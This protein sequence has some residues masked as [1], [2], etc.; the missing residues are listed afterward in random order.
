MVLYSNNFDTS[1]IVA[2]GVS[3]TLTPGLIQ[4]SIPLSPWWTGDYYA[5]QTYAPSI[6]SL[7]GAVPA[8]PIDINLTLGFLGSWDS[9]DGH[10]LPDYLDISING[11]PVLM[12]L[13]SNNASGTIQTYGGG[14]VVGKPVIA[15]SNY[16][17]FSDTI[18]DMTTASSLSFTQLGGSL[19]FEILGY[20]GGYS[21]TVTWGSNPNIYDE[22]WGIDNLVI[23]ANNNQSVPAPLPLLGAVSAYRFSRRLKARIRQGNQRRMAQIDTQA[24]L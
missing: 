22:G 11:S 16:L 20:G 15:T 7:T 12:K 13:T 8:G 10:G 17:H 23:T 24:P 3:A 21:P 2:A 14:I 4:T 18:V 6:L 9:S 1:P 19:T 5:N